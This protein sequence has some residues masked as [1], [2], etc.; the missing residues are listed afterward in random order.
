[1]SE[2]LEMLAEG[3]IGNRVTYRIREQPPKILEEAPPE[4]KNP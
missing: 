1:M 2:L 3:Q 4:P